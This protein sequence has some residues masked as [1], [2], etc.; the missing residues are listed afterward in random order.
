MSDPHCI[1]Q[2]GITWAPLPGFGALGEGAHHGGENP[3]SSVGIFVAEISP[4]KTP[5]V[6]VGPV[7]VTSPQFS[8]VSM[9]LL[10]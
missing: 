10:M 2:P 7:I 3:H 1:S 5:H 6:G 8:P 4:P 9:W